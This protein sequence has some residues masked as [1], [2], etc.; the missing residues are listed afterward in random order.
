M[1]KADP[2][3]LLGVDDRSEQQQTHRPGPPD[4]SRGSVIDRPESAVRPIPVNAGAKRTPPAA[5]RKSQAKAKP[6]PAPAHVPLIAAM[7]GF[8][9]VARLCTIGL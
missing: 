3:G 2:L 6:M 9:I 5:I 4:R 7:T 8:G 1:D